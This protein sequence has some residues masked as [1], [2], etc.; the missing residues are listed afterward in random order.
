[1]TEE[2]ARYRKDLSSIPPD[3]PYAVLR[4]FVAQRSVLDVGCGSGE[5]G[6]YL[7]DGGAVVDGI[8]ADPERAAEAR[9]RLHAVAEGLA[10]PG[11]GSPALADRYDVVVLA[12]VVEHVAAPASLLT[13][14]ADRLEPGGAAL[15]LLP[16][17]AHH[18]FR[19]R[20]LRGD[21]RYEDHGLLDRDHVRFYDTHTMGELTQGT[22]LVE[23]GRRYFVRPRR[24]RPIERR[25][26]HR[27]P[28]L[29]AYYALLEWRHR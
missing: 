24:A 10:G 13:W 21:W 23:T 15:C 22:P 28:N 1:M 7:A 2:A 3:H 25:L 16:N 29:F 8:E 17:S 19:R 6:A 27:W 5:L 4:S 12:D 26:I 20:M 11:F 14:V 18:S 9:R